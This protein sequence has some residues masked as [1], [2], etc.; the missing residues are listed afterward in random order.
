MSKKRR[1]RTTA[2]R[3]R[4]AA[5]EVS[6]TAAPTPAAR[7][8][9]P[10][11]RPAS[12]EVSEEGWRWWAAT[13]SV[14]ALLAATAVLYD[15]GS[16]APFYADRSAAQV[17]LALVLAVLVLLP[18][19]TPFTGVRFDLVDALAVAFAL[20]QVIATAVS[21]APV[22]AVFGAYNVGRGTLF[23][24]AVVL[25]FL[26]VRRLLNGPR[27]QAA[28]V[29]IVAAILVVAAVVATIQAFGLTTLWAAWGSEVRINRVPGTAGSMTN[30]GGL[31]LLAVW[32]LAGV[33]RWRRFGPTWWAAAVGSVAGV[34]CIS[35][36]VTRAAV[37][38]AA[39]GLV[40][41]AVLW[42][43][44]RRRG[45]L[46][47]LGVVVIA[48]VLTS[49]VYALGPGDSLFGR[50]GGE[51]GQGVYTAEA[52]RMQIWQAGL[53]G[54]AA[55]PLFGVGP[56]GFV[57]DYRRY[58]PEQTYPIP[59]RGAADAH[60]LPV[61]L[62]AGSGVPG[63]LFAIVF[64]VLVMRLLWRRRRRTIGQL[65][66]SSVS[67]GDSDE[68][69]AAEAALL[70]VLAAG[71]CLVVSPSDAVIVLPAVVI[72]AAACGP[73]RTGEGR[74]WEL[75]GGGSRGVLAVVRAVLLAATCLALVVAVVFGA[76]W[77]SADRALLAAAKDA[78][79][80]AE[81]RRASDLA[82]WEP[83]YALK[84]GRALIGDA[85][86]RQDAAGIDAGRAYVKR[87]IAADPTALTGYA[88]LARLDM[89]MGQPAAAIAEL[90]TATRW[91]PHIPLL[92]GLWGY[93]ALQAQRDLKQ[94]GLAKD[95]ADGLSRLPV[96]TPDGW[97]W[98][99]QALR[100]MGDAEGA[101]AAL[102]KA[103]AL[104]PD[105]DEAAFKAR[106]Q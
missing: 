87:G 46:V 25:V 71:C 44:R 93:A 14:A 58:G 98:L 102:A 54:I 70:A 65:A 89:S 19:R 11:A 55:R 16:N 37:I 5:V 9:A 81:T 7:A 96:D 66:G 78:T 99:G 1:Q 17:V 12:S 76:R 29:W 42:V 51:K 4:G 10:T 88:D 52:T 69:T 48:G 18:G 75:G 45:D 94:P 32:L 72:A 23:W 41:L 50:L 3:R 61:Q 60:S 64:A 40:L 26:S 15:P 85:Q 73:P 97:F 101:S 62:A 67:P 74:V 22:L 82:P 33:G 20:W 47:L 8:A 68:G 31:G 30:L 77:W 106:L 21:P 104:M 38:G 6:A 86:Q 43:L 100:A 2:G 53:Q 36:S 84:A 80:V 35:L 57:M 79:A 103:Q 34:V 24:L 83:W 28:L 63:L 27:S 39:L 49:T 13:A 92:Q 59:F 105:L 95:L 56:G 91:N 90:R